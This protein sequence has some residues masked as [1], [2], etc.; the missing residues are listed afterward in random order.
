MKIFCGILASGTGERFLNKKTPKQLLPVGGSTLFTI[1]LKKID[2]SGL[3]DR[4]VVS[5]LESFESSFLDCIESEPDLNKN[6]NITTTIGGETRMDSIL[7]VIRNIEGNY[8]IED[9]DIFCLVDSNRPLID[10]D[11]YERVVKAAIKYSIS[12]PSRSLSD[13]VGVVKKGF[14]TNIPDKEQLHSIQTPEACNFNKLLQLIKKGG[15]H[16]KLGLCEIFLEAGIQPKVVESDYK[17]HKITHPEDI[18]VIEAF[19]KNKNKIIG[20]I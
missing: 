14:L 2:D 6:N 11:L 3:F 5:L 20:I 12:C 7:S 15:H 9:D 4:V 19:I 16:G 1:T 13:G 17:T 18:L 8:R 10:K